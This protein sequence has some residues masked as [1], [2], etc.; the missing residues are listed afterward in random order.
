MDYTTQYLII[1][2]RCLLHTKQFIESHTQITTLAFSYEGDFLGMPISYIN[3]FL[4]VI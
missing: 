1:S 4:S 3:V 2:S